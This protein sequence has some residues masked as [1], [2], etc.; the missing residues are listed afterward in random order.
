[1][2]R[3]NN[4]SCMRV[5]LLLCMVVMFLLLLFTSTTKN[6]WMLD[7][8]NSSRSLMQ[9]KGG[10]RMLGK[11][12]RQRRDSETRE[13]TLHKLLRNTDKIP[14]KLHTPRDRMSKPLVLYTLFAGRQKT[15][16]IQLPHVMEL[17][18][19]NV[20]D[21][22][23][24]WDLTC[25]QEAEQKHWGLAKGSNDTKYLWE[26]VWPMDERIYII[27]PPACSWRKY[28]E[29]YANLLQPDDVLMKVDDDIIFL[30][31][32]RVEGF[33]TTIRK[34][35]QVY[36]WSAAVINNGVTAG[37]HSSDGT[38]LPKDVA[39]YNHE[40]HYPLTPGCLFG[41]ATAGLM[42]HRHFLANS[43]KYYQ[44]PPDKELRLVKGR[45]SINFVAWLGRNF[46][47][48]ISYMRTVR[49]DIDAG[50]GDEYVITALGSQ[51]FGQKLVVYLPFVVAHASFGQQHIYDRV[52]A[53]YKRAKKNL[54]NQGKWKFPPGAAFAFPTTANI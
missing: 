30:D 27:T 38:L 19:K 44:P 21:E 33:V 40:I 17:L 9:L 16:S 37:I 20:I 2:I 26:E 53:M 5:T 7:G 22:V 43:Q 51:Y 13:E 28:Y 24:L 1:M 47:Q 48:T 15:L 49:H 36:L 32:S 8:N 6:S 34:H 41:N 52:S 12:K 3:F 50:G 11:T 29:Y 45:I 23:H 54:V 14:S 25:K 35:P 39:D 31:T 10:N 18:K 46:K 42:V 4:N